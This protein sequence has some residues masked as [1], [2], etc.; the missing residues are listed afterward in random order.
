MD[1]IHLARRW[2]DLGVLA[3]LVVGGYGVLADI[4]IGIAGAF[5]GGALFA[6]FGWHTPFTGLASVVFIAFIGAVILL[7]VLHLIR[8]RVVP[9]R[10]RIRA[11][12]ILELAT[13]WTRDHV[14]AGTR[15]SFGTRKLADAQ[16]AGRVDL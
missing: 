9:V 3:G 7:V 13:R 11:L 16:N 2:S 6:H 10:D 8:G 14:T 5:I 1:I 4:V 12:A 15:R